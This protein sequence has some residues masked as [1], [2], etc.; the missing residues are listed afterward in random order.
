MRTSQRKIE[1][2]MLQ[3]SMSYLRY[4]K[5]LA[6]GESLKHKRALRVRAI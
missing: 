6:E 4:L 5:F 1:E 2:L 3:N